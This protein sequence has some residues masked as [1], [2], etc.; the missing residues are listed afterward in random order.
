MMCYKDMTFDISPYCV[1]DCGRKLTDKIKIEA[2]QARL[3]L[4][5]ASFCTESHKENYE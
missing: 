5:M 2:E 4:S 3:P 1:N